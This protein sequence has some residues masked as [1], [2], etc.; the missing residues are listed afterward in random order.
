MTSKNFLITKINAIKGIFVKANEDDKFLIKLIPEEVS[1]YLNEEGGFNSANAFIEDK[2]YS[3]DFIYYEDEEVFIFYNSISPD[4]KIYKMNDGSYF[5]LDDF[6]K[7]RFN[8]SLLF[9]QN[10]LE[11]KKT[12]L[13]L[14]ESSKPV[15]YEK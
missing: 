2:K 11:G 8:H 5:Q 15:L 13:I 9:G 14:K 6:P 3:I 1:K 4:L 10:I 12:N 7:I